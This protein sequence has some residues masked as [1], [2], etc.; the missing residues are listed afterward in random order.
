[1]TR[2]PSARRLNNDLPNAKHLVIPQCGHVP[3]V[4]QPAKVTQALLAFLGEHRTT[5]PGPAPPD[6]APTKPVEPDVEGVL[7]EVAFQ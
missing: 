2:L 6:K 5:A 7:E 3:F 1:M 4:E